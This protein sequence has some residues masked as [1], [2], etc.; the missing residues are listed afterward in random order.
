MR[1]SCKWRCFPFSK[2]LITG[3]PDIVS[4]SIPQ[5]YNFCFTGWDSTYVLRCTWIYS[6]LL[7]EVF[8]NSNI[9]YRRGDVGFYI[10]NLDIQYVI[11]N[12]YQAV[13]Q[14]TIESRLISVKL[15]SN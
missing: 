2:Y 14:E 7:G 11:N 15:S 12:C 3:Y 6:I 8:V 5:Q 9:N 10:S 4:R 1:S 13:I